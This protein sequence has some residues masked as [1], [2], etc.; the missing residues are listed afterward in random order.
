MRDDVKLKPCPFCGAEA[1]LKHS[2]TW[3]YFVRCTDCGA[4]TRQHHEND[5]G[6][7]YGWNRRSYEPPEGAALVDE[8]GEV[9]DCE[10]IAIEHE[11]A[12]RFKEIVRCRDCRGYRPG[13]LFG[14][15]GTHMTAIP[16]EDGFCAWGIPADSGREIPNR[17]LNHG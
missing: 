10:L 8:F 17:G 13:E 14:W 1:E 12:R 5:V 9:L 3:D 11:M 16:R 2:S 6:A 4:R 15:C 7:V